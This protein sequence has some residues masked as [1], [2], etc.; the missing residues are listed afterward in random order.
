[1]NEEQKKQNL[2]NNLKKSINDII[3][4]KTAKYENEICNQAIYDFSTRKKLEICHDNDPPWDFS[5]Q[6]VQ[7]KGTGGF[8]A[9]DFET[10]G[11]FMEMP[12]GNSIATYVSRYGM[13][14]QTFGEWYEEE[15]RNKFAAD[16]RTCIS[17]LCWQDL[18]FLYKEI[19][20]L[21][22]KEETEPKCEHERMAYVWEIEDNYFPSKNLDKTIE[23]ME[24]IKK[25]PFANLLKKHKPAVE[26]RLSLEKALAEKRE[27]QRE[28]DRVKAS[29]IWKNVQNAHMSKHGMQVG[30][31][32]NKNNYRAFMET[33]AGLRITRNEA[34]LLAD[35]A[36]LILSNSVR[37][38]LTSQG[39]TK[40]EKSISNAYLE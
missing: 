5:G 3:T 40:T 31:N 16:I 34:R 37:R 4:S 7:A 33:L 13:H 17:A 27:R 38:I 12:N 26:K 29:A 9:S 1:M 30:K 14:H 6:I 2:L 23:T 35:F 10:L 20:C 15:L 25:A 21:P 32:L 39:S 19:H 36:P 18:L 24:R 28:I 11:D 8:L 22:A